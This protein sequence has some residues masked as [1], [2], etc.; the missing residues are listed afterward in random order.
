MVM[1]VPADPHYI[2]PVR[3]AVGGL[4]SLLD[5]TLETID[6]LRIAVD[7]LCAALLET[8]DGSPLELD[9]SSSRGSIR[10]V[11]TTSAGGG[12]VDEDRVKF[13]RQIL[14]V[15]ADEFGFEI[16][17]GL[18]RCWIERSLEDSADDQPDG[19]P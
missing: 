12:E 1:R 14:S 13:S 7:E 19:A 16:D 17:D 3:L 11:G 4:A 5:V 18:V 8:G 10:I 6:D 2:R 9:I 15:I